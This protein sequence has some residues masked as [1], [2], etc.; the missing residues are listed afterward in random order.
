MSALASLCGA[1][2]SSDCQGV[3][4]RDNIDAIRFHR[5]SQTSAAQDEAQAAVL[6][7]VGNAV[8][9]IG[10]I[11]RNVGGAS[12]QDRE[13]ADHE[14][15]RPVQIE[16]DQ[17]IG[18]SASRHKLLATRLAWRSS[19]RYVSERS[20]QTRA[21]ASGLR[22]ACASINLWISAE[23]SKATAVSLHW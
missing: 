5:S 11:K 4:D 16:A 20:S 3:F 17:P 9:R 1:A 12:L 15:A 13:R 22:A 18:T 7:H 10:R 19:S 2:A 23:R 21:I 14:F 6:D 8:G